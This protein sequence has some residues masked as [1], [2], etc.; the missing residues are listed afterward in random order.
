MSNDSANT[1]VGLVRDKAIVEKKVSEELQ[2]RQNVHL[3][4]GDMTDYGSL[5]KAVDETA[6]ITGGALDYVIANAAFMSAW[7]AW[8][9]VSVLYVEPLYGRMK[10]ETNDVHKIG[11]TNPN[12]SSK[13]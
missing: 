7:S 4:Q 11:A 1:V 13:T 3:V 2:N 12:N 8:D 5:K 6:G 9:P 10:N